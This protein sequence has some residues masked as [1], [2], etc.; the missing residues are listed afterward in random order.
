MDL[1][2]ACSVADPG[3]GGGLI[4]W[5]IDFY[6]GFRINAQGDVCKSKS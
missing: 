3:G 5:G 6:S 1:V 2:F 4:P